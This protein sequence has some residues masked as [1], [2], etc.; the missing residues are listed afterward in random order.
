MSRIVTLAERG[1]FLPERYRDTDWVAPNRIEECQTLALATPADV[2]AA[3]SAAIGETRRAR[4]DAVAASRLGGVVVA[5]EDLHDPHNG[6]AVLRSCEALGIHEI[7]VIANSELFRTSSKVTQGCDKWLEVVSH[8][9]TSQCLTQLKRRGFCIYAAVPGA[10]RSLE[11]LDAQRPAVFL[12]GNEHNGL[13]Q[14]ARQQCDEEFSI[15]LHGFSESVNL[16]VATALIAYTHA[17]RRR[18][19]MGHVSDLDDA[20]LLELRA[21]YYF[22]DV[23]GATSMVRRYV[24][25]K[26]KVPAHS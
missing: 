26:A 2:I 9:D 14:A 25:A 7:H 13:S 24:A 12:M 15:P 18:Q 19:A 11:E 16:S 21:R 10:K 1:R 22:R 23:R 6:G 8:T 3:L 5:L 20:A 17:T 4:L